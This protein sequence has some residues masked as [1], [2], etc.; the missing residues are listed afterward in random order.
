MLAKLKQTYRWGSVNIG[1]VEIVKSDYRELPEELCKRHAAILDIKA[2]DKPA[3]LPNNSA[4]IKT[5]PVVI[6]PVVEP[7][8]ET[9][10]VESPVI[11]QVETLHEFKRKAKFN[12]E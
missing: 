6:E 10:V 9:P 12:K 4:E 7:V 11:E 1:S 3:K 5:A 8:I 2:G